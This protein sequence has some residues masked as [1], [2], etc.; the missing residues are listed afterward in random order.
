MF[1]FWLH[2]SLPPA[3]L[4]LFLLRALPLLQSHYYTTHMR[5]HSPT[6]SGH[7]RLNCLDHSRPNCNAQWKQGLNEPKYKSG[8]INLYCDLGAGSLWPTQCIVKYNIFFQL[9]CLFLNYHNLNKE[10]S[11]NEILN[12]IFLKM[13]SIRKKSQKTVK[14]TIFISGYSNF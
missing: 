5:H 8:R 2:C 4:L 13:S 10:T 6:L 1:F 14:N 9:F 11:R 7:A 3:I 12:L